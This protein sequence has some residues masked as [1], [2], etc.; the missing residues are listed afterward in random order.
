MAADAFLSYGLYHYATVIASCCRQAKEKRKNV[1]KK[2]KKRLCAVSH[3]K[4][5]L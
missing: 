2:K 4:E 1:E 5:N 3:S